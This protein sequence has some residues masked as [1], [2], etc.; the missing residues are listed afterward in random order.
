MRLSIVL[1]V[2]SIYFRTSYSVVC[3][4]EECQ[5]QCAAYCFGLLN[6]CMSNMANLQRRT[7]A[8]EAA[9]T[10]ARIALNDRRLDTFGFPLTMHPEKKNT[11][12]LLI[13]PTPEA[14]KLERTDMFHQLGNKS[15][16]IEKELKLNWHDALEKCHKM[17]G[18]LASPQNQ[19]EL[20]SI[21]SK[22][23]G[24][25]RYWI[26]VTSQF[27]DDEY[28]SI[29]KGSKAKFLSWADGEPTK[30]GKCVDIRT[31]NGKTTM[32]DNNCTASLYFVCEKS[33]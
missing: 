33:I 3:E 13:A 10:I 28:V 1:V 4:G 22:F 16:Y 29:T 15:Y 27:K 20:N 24:L 30:D 6:P 25:N 26:D 31:F 11:S 14:R 19:E 9:V 2:L 21:G 7:E 5:E 12:Q 17:G 23:D 32:N 18:H 8:C